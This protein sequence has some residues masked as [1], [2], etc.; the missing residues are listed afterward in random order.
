MRGLRK[1]HCMMTSM[2][3]TP[4]EL[5]QLTGRRRSSAQAMA[6][7][8]MGMEHKTRPDGTVAVLRAHVERVFGES[9][10]ASKTREEEPNWSAL[11]TSSPCSQ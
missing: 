6:L 4:D 7:C 11:A 5:V 9:V 3:L 2:F 8:R 10:S 1:R